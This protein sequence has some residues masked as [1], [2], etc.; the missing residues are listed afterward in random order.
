MTK[1]RHFNIENS[2]LFP[3]VCEDDA[4]YKC[5]LQICINKNVI[6]SNILFLF[7]ERN[8]QKIL[9]L[10]EWF[11]VQKKRWKKAKKESRVSVNW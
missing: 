4:T 7:F 5:D 11:K 8:K 10:D 9:S 6:L 2:G 1:I 3:D